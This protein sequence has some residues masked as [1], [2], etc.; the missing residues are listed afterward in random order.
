MRCGDAL[1]RRADLAAPV[2]H[3]DRHRRERQRSLASE[4]ATRNPARA[5]G[6]RSLLHER[7]RPRCAPQPSYG[8]VPRGSPRR[9]FLLSGLESRLL[10]GLDAHPSLRR[11]KPR[12]ARGGTEL[13]RWSPHTAEMGIRPDGDRD[14]ETRTS[15]KASEGGFSVAGLIICGVDDS[16]SAKG[17]AAAVARGLSSE[18]GLRTRVSCV[19][20]ESGASKRKGRRRHQNG[21]SASERVPRAKWTTRAAVW[22]VDEGHPAEQARRRRSGGGGDR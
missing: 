17:A 12:D 15:R 5:A 1:G 20:L 14:G 13:C 19:L 9:A 22:L 3:V 6:E 11:R 7:V 8:V 2:E 18:R 21:S 16:E 10:P 4:A